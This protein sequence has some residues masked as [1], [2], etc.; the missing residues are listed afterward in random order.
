MRYMEEALPVSKKLSRFK[1][2][3]SLAFLSLYTALY[4]AIIMVYFL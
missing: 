4:N 1:S 2:S 3:E